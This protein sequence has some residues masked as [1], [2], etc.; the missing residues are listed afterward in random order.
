MGFVPGCQNNQS[1]DSNNCRL[2]QLNETGTDRGLTSYMYRRVTECDAAKNR[3][4]G[5]SKAAG[6]I[7]AKLYPVCGMVASDKQVESITLRGLDFTR[8]VVE[9]GNFKA[10]TF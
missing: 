9:R 10:A 2:R 7:L 4:N 5:D 8:T 1:C 6:T 3:T